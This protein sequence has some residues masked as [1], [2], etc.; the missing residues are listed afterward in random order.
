MLHV[1][2]K[3]FYCL[4]FTQALFF[5]IIFSLFFLLLRQ[6]L[7]GKRFW[8]AA[9]A[10]V[11]L[12]WLCF[13]VSATLFDRG[14]SESRMAPALL[15]FFSY[16]SVLNGG[17]EEILRS[18]FMNVALFFPIGLLG[19]ELLPEKWPRRKKL[20]FVCGFLMLLSVGI[21]CCQFCFALGQAETDDVIHNTLGALIGVL[22]CFIKGKSASAG[23]VPAG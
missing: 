6:M 21:E 10:L 19:C 9:V 20:F 15:P 11:A 23:K 17:N 12:F 1:L 18:N 8:W 4:P 13:I 2:L 14:I 5:L 3:W 7:G 22:T 16:Y